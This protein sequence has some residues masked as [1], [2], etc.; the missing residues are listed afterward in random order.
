M[1]QKIIVLSCMHGRQDTVK[2]CLDK[3]PFIDKIMIHSTNQDGDFL[4][5]TDVVAIGQFK[6]NPLSY[7]WNAAVMSLENL[8]FDAVILLGSDDYIDE[9]FV[10]FVGKNI[11]KYEM[12]AFT[13]IYF[14]D[15]GGLFYWSGYEGTRKGEPCGAGKVYTKKFL[16]RIKYNLFNEAKERGLDGVSWRRCKQAN[17]NVL[18]TSLKENGLFLCDVKDGEGMTELKNLNNLQRVK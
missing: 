12:I 2:Y 16:E 5:G 1:E 9:A 13:D 14:K 7:K 15:E 11:N 10:E 4:A 18:V 8:D 6:N 17:V 3:M